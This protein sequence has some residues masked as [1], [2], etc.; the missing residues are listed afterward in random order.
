MAD[1][2]EECCV[3][4]LQGGGAL[5]A[6]QA[7]VYEALAAA[8]HQPQWVAGISIGAINAAL[9]AGN[10]PERRVEALRTFWN[11]ASS[12]IPLPSPFADGWGRRLFNEASAAT[13]AMTG[14]PGFFTPRLCPPWAALPGSPESISLYDTAPLRESL[15]E[16]VD[17][18]LLNTGP[19]RFSVGAVNVLTGNFVYFDNRDRWIGPEHVM[20]S[21]ALPPGFPPVL[22]DGEPYWDGGLVS[23]TPL[24]W[25]LDERAG[26]TGA[27]PL[28]V[29][30]VDLFSARGT[31]PRSLAEAAEREKD[32]RFS[33]RTRLNTD[34]QKRI[35][36][37]QAAAKRL[38]A[39]LPAGFEDD[40]DLALLTAHACE[41]PV[42][43]MHLINRPEDYESHGKDYE[44]SRSTVQDHWRSG[45]G[46]VTRS[47]ASPRWKR[48]RIP[49]SGV[50]TLDL[51]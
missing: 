3:L 24:Q 47:L 40:P 35:E 39:R 17:W 48:R 8:H 19:M 4:V 30:Q 15:L 18:N 32:I 28:L 21:G 9:I 43:I 7:G 10:P 37:L 31:M 50:V 13:V 1:G 12:R 23:N 45:Q 25:V 27:K 6:Y 2:A 11:R 33:S 22:V 49:A 41:G 5:G 26:E 16:L 29:F 36:G 34:M 20:A 14:I 42:T 46:D 38:A 51:A 44:F